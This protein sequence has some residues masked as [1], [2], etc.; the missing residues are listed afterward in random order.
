MNDSPELCARRPERDRPGSAAV[1]PRSVTSLSPSSSNSDGES[2]EESLSEGEMARLKEE[3]E[4]K[5]KLISN[6][7]NKP[8]RMKRRL[9]CLK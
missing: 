9:K 7:R 8:W 1:S 6:M 5:K 2:D 4:D 3:V